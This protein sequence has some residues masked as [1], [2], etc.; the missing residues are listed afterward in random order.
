MSKSNPSNIKMTNA[1]VVIVVDPKSQV[2]RRHR[3]G[4]LIFSSMYTIL[5]LGAFFGWGPMQLLVRNLL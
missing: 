3:T 5:Y 4:L 2:Q 1:H